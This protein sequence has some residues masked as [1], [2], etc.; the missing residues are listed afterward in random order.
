MA[1]DYQ[2]RKDIDRLYDLIWD[3]DTQQLALVT[4]DELQDILDYLSIGKFN[5]EKFNFAVADDKFWIMSNAKYNYDA[6]R[7]V[8]LDKT[9]TSFAICLDSNMDEHDFRFYYNPPASQVA[10]D[11][12]LYDYTDYIINGYLGTVRKTDGEYILYNIDIG[13]TAVRFYPQTDGKNISI[14]SDGQASLFVNESLRL[15]QFSCYIP[16]E[17]FSGGNLIIATIPSKY[18]P[19]Q[20]IVLPFTN[21][22]MVGFIDSIGNVRASLDPSGESSVETSAMWHY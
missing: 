17:T 15:A 11:E 2:T 16:T 9:Y 22:N 7:F 20:T 14:E 3:N 13:W 4:K 8:K 5:Y 6:M 12:E 18:A 10:L 1:E 19:Q 21:K